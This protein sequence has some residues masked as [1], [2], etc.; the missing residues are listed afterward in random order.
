[1]HGVVESTWVLYCKQCFFSANAVLESGT[2]VRV[3]ACVDALCVSA[4]RQEPSTVVT[5][6]CLEKSADHE[7]RLGPY[8]LKN[9][10]EVL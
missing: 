5:S 6:M 3:C 10:N 8:L 9:Y 2:L 4:L 7:Y 1:M